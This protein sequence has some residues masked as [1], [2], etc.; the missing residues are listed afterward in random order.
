MNQEYSTLPVSFRQ[1]F[2]EVLSES[3]ALGL[4]SDVL[5]SLLLQPLVS[6]HFNDAQEKVNSMK[7]LDI[8]ER[9]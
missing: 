6:D 7:S 4:E 3:E 9:C 8:M 1:V 2:S 5:L